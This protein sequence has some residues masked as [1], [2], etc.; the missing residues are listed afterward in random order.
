[1]TCFSAV[2]PLRRALSPVYGAPLV[3]TTLRRLREA[4]LIGFGTGGRGGVGS[5]PVSYH[6]AALVLLALIA[7]TEPR[8]CPQAAL[9]LAS[10]RLTSHCQPLVGECSWYPVPEEDQIDFGTYLA[11]EIESA[12]RD[13]T[14]RTIA[15]D[16]AFGERIAV[17]DE[18]VL[19]ERY[20][21]RGDPPNLCDANA[22]CERLEFTPAVQR[23]R[24]PSAPGDLVV[25]GRLVRSGLIRCIASAF[26][27]QPA[28][29]LS[30]GAA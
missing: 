21:E 13:P 23:P 20:R 27:P 7:D 6:Q 5:A 26:A 24:R 30:G 12:S 15:L 3:D 19:L 1:V 16:I 22:A 8:G 9:E 10:Y 28:T 11:G 17:M 25:T 18:A 14:A 29:I 2:A 4:G